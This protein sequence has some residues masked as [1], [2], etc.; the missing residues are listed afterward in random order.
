LLS[1]YKELYEA[2]AIPAQSLSGYA[3]MKAFGE[4]Q[5]AMAFCGSWGIGQ[6]KNT[7]PDKDCAGIASASYNSL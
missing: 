2:E 3:D 7:Y 4:G 1:L 6:L 5:L